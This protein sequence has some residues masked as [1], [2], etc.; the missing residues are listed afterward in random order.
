MDKESIEIFSYIR[1]RFAS[2]KVYLTDDMKLSFLPTS[3]FLGY[4]VSFEGKHNPEDYSCTVS[5]TLNMGFSIRVKT[6][7]TDIITSMDQYEI[8]AVGYKCTNKLPNFEVGVDYLI[9][10]IGDKK[11]LVYDMENNLSLQPAG[12]FGFK[13]KEEK[14][15]DWRK[16]FDY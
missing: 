4:I 7:L 13:K 5:L 1:K 2:G 15:D 10:G 14:Y 6:H 12:A 11:V 9:I 8:E 3:C 16:S